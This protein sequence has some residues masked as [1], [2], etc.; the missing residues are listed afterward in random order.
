MVNLATRLVHTP[1]MITIPRLKADTNSLISG[2]RPMELMKGPKILLALR[3]VHY[4][5]RITFMIFSRLFLAMKPLS[6]E[7]KLICIQEKRLESTP[8]RIAWIVRSL[9]SISM[10]KFP[11]FVELIDT[12]TLLLPLISSFLL[13]PFW[14]CLLL[15]RMKRHLR[16]SQS[17]GIYSCCQWLHFHLPFLNISLMT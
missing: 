3:W 17:P 11:E 6:K 8:E 2:A 16:S 14:L 1:K 10:S 5:D 15:I 9:I 12:W 4:S 7:V 13:F